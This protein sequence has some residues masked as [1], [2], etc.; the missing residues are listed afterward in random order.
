MGLETTAVNQIKAE[1]WITFKNKVRHRVT[2][3]TSCLKKI[4]IGHGS[5]PNLEYYDY[6]IPF[7]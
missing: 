1:V 5:L 7:S 2:C 4:T 3:L 6:L